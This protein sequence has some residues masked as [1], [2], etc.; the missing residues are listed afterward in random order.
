MVFSALPGVKSELEQISARVNA[1]VLFDEDFTKANLSHE[2]DRVPFPILH[3]ATHGQF[4]S[5]RE[6]TFLLAWDQRIT[7]S[8]LD[9]LLRSRRQQSEPIELMVLSA[10]QTAEGDDRAALGL[11]GMALRSGARST[12]AT[13]WAVND[14]STAALM[15]EFYQFLEDTDLSKA[16]AL[17]LAQIKILQN[18]KFSHPYYWSPFVLIGNWLS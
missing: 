12:L 1:E 9:D 18:P 6:K 3:L 11:A 15:A 14:E 2:I 13:L 5:D 8:D 10:C 17:R 7:L 16:E 4:S